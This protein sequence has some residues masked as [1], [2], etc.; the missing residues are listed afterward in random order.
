MRFLGFHDLPWPTHFCKLPAL[1]LSL[2]CHSILFL[3]Q[4]K[5]RLID[6]TFLNSVIYSFIAC[7]DK[8]KEL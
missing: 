2:I 1:I 3:T 4:G 8:L 7:Q 5:E 6:S